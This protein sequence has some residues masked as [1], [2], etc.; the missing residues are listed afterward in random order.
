LILSLQKKS[1]FMIE[2]Y[3]NHQLRWS[4]GFDNPNKAAMIF[5]CLVP[6]FLAMLLFGLRR[7]PEER[8]R[9]PWVV[10]S[11]LGL[12]SVLF[13]LGKTCSRGGLLA[14]GIAALWVVWDWW[15][16]QRQQELL[17]AREKSSRWPVTAVV[18]TLG[19][20][21]LAGGLLWMTGV[22]HRLWLP[23]TMADASVGN[24]L[25]LWK[26]ALVMAFENPWGM[27][28][29][30]SGWHYMQWYQPVDMT[31]AYRTLVNSYLTFLVERGWLIFAGILLLAGFLWFW[32]RPSRDAFPGQT[33]LLCGCRGL[34]VAFAVGGV[35]ST[36]MENPWLWLVPGLAL[37]AILWTRHVAWRD[38]FG[39]AGMLAGFATLIIL[40]SL[41]LGGALLARQSGWE[42]G[43]FQARNGSL[44]IVTL[45]P[46][47][48]TATSRKLVF[49]ADAAV[50]GGDFGKRIREL[51]ERLRVPVRVILVHNDKEKVSVTADSCVVACGEA[52]AWP[53]S[54]RPKKIIWLAP[55]PEAVPNDPASWQG[56]G[57]RTAELWLPSIDEDGRVL[58]WQKLADEHHWK[59]RTLQGVG[60]QVTW[61]WEQVLTWLGENPVVC[62]P[63]ESSEKQA[64]L[65]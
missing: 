46:P 60:T 63:G 43:F 12:L 37:L 3:Y 20:A 61:A 34:W 62:L 27:G 7:I 22:L 39:R 9:W 5:A 16:Q 19:T 10:I 44:A 59:I 45:R 18:L 31:A 1:N 35:F 56:D 48:M 28:A 2:Y 24:R 53:L 64:S 38:G 40:A 41:W 23:L 13:C 4:F 47:Q 29:G 17:H 42:R 51:S 8:R 52:A 21:G 25:V 36:T 57:T 6:V 14:A 49:L 55:A 54:C 58:R 33:S 30:K 26:Q 32:A 50:L 65:L 15:R 11:L